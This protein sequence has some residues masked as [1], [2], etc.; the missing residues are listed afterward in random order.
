MKS[1]AV[2]GSSATALAEI[3]V[4]CATGDDDVTRRRIEQTLTAAGMRVAASTA[5]V[6]Q[7]VRACLE[8]PAHALVLA[9]ELSTAASGADLRRLRKGLPELPIVV[10]SL[11]TQPNSVRKALAAG[12]QGYVRDADIEQ[13]LPLT[14]RAVCA[15]QICVPRQGS[16]Q[17]ER[18]SFSLREK[19]VLELVA[20]GFTNAEIALHLHLAESTVKAHLSTSFRKLGVNSRKDAAAIVLDP[21]NGLGL[22]LATISWADGPARPDGTP[23]YLA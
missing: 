6:E 5:S 2:F 3:A 15:G 21:D 12:A 19:Q 22:G 11:A 8:T 20:R 13:L 7:L 4:A 17:I 18:P 10:A 1:S 14:I 16:D 23:A 9:C